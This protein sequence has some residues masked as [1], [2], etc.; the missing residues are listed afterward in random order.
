LA[1][2]A[3]ILDELARP[4][5]TSFIFLPMHVVNHA[6]HHKKSIKKRAYRPYFFLAMWV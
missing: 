1:A 5:S 6:F 3:H 4:L 2:N